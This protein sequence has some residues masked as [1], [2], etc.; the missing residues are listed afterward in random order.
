MHRFR[1]AVA[2]R[3]WSLPL[4]DKLRAATATGATGVQ[5]DVREELPTGSLSETGLRDFLHVVRELGL[6][7]ASTVFPLRHPLASE[8]QLDRR[9]AAIREAMQFTYQLG[10]STLCLPAGRLPEDRTAREGTL[11]FEVLGDLARHGNHAGVTLALTPMGDPAERLRDWVNNITT[12]PVG[13]DFDPAQFAQAG[14]STSESLRTL[15][16]LVS[17]VQLRDGVRTL[18]G[19]GEET[20]FGQGAVDWIEFLALLNEMDYPG[21]L[22]ALRTGGDDRPRDVARAVTQV[23]KWLF[24][25]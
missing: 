10:A 13:I 19:G 20:A 23:K 1:L 4:L 3:T 2:T 9:L 25:S 5:V 24:M 11:L 15:H 16:G 18:T 8:Y 17:H 21:W 12:G 7:V 22:T 14:H 6:S